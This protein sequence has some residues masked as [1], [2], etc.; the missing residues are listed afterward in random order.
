MAEKDKNRYQNL[1]IPTYDEATSSRPTSSQSRVG[2][3]E[4]SDDAERQ[5]LLRYS[6]RNDPSSASRYAPP[7]VESARS[8][9]DLPS[10]DGLDRASIDS[11]RQEMQQ[12]EV[13]EPNSD[14]GSHRS[15][16]TYR[17]S[18]RITIFTNSFSSL[19]FPSLR[20]YIPSIRW[21][22]LNFRGSDNHVIL[23][24]RLFGAFLIVS[25]AYLLIASDIMSF[26][27]QASLAQMYNPESVRIFVQESMNEN[28]KI[29]EYLEYITR[30]PHMAGTEGNYILGEWVQELFKQSELEDINMERFDVYLNYPRQGGRKVAIIE[31][32]DLRWEAV[33]EEELAYDNP[34]RQQTDVFHGHSKAA[35]VTGP[36]IYANYGSREDFQKLEDSGIS[37]KG[38][39]VLVRHYGTQGD[40]ALKVKAAELAG[41]A[42]CII[43]SDP[44]QDGFVQGKVWPDGRYMSADAVQRGAVSL[45]SWVVGDVLSPGWASTPGEKRRLS[46]TESTGLNQIPSIPIAWRDAQHLLQSLKGHGQQVAEDWRG[47]VPD[48]DWWSGD[49]K[50]PIVHLMNLQ[51][52]E[53]FQPIYNVLGRINGWEQSEK[54]V[55]VGNHRDAWCFGGV[56]PGSGTAIMLEVVRVFGELRKRGWR[57]LR[58]IEFASWDGE[59]YNLIGSTEHVENR[60]DELRRDG[61]AYLN[62]DMGVIG[63]DFHAAASPLF[64]RALLRVL[65]RTSDPVANRTLREIW[66]EKNIGLEGLGA[67]S[68]YVAFQDIVGTSSIDMSFKG[69]HYPYHS[70]YDNYE[71]VSKFGDPDFAYH[72]LM[73]E[74]WALLI[75]EIADRPILPYD[76]KAYARA[77]SRYV[78]DLEDYGKKKG[79]PWGGDKP[80]WDLSP[81]QHASQYFEERAK[82]FH[83]WDTAW[84]QVV[85]G[86]GGA[87]ETNVMAIRRMS[88]NSRMAEFETHLLDLED[89]GGVNASY[90][91]LM[92]TSLTSFCS[93]L[94]EHNLNT[95]SLLP[96]HGLDTMKRSFRV[97]GMQWMQVTGKR[98]KSKLRKSPIFCPRR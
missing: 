13:E 81:L 35:N 44:A 74:V 63:S 10:L 75:L 16:L 28:G 61:F 26:R 14:N 1:P 56:D 97:S 54:R 64:E 57:P 65:D 39:V 25:V 47:G 5:G 91:H 3:E 71:W 32:P 24:G 51:D 4:I 80:L 85:F 72:K 66:D 7:T 48:V 50:S 78:S 22:S 93:Y 86:S 31:P 76:M 30:Y 58:T 34:P 67:G 18:K 87:F 2:P 17:F 33:I 40:R 77:V 21:P 19:N 70:C 94:A 11:L 52:E 27:S 36:L 69:P 55:I 68:D 20:R 8:S 9:L 49:S 6:N 45:M 42:G 90:S 83:E 98:P 59:E 53:T 92:Y 82:I 95:L 38:A 73:G 23:L 62:V 41:A 12:M 60:L 89:G 15:L 96:K 84:N 43:Y 46:P 79:A 37:L 88:H 29:Q